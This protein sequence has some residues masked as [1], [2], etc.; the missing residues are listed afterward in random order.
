MRTLL[1]VIFLSLTSYFVQAEQFNI[2]QVQTMNVATDYVFDFGSQ[3][4]NSATIFL[5]ENNSFEG[6]IAIFFGLMIIA[7]GLHRC[8]IMVER[9]AIH[10]G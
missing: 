3:A 1:V 7:I 5:F 10:N 9:Y 2:P 6:L 4:S 8:L